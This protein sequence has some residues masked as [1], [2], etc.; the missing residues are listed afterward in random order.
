LL[1]SFSTSVL[2]MGGWSA[3]R[4]GR[5]T[6]GKDPVHIV[7]ENEWAAGPVWTC[8]KNLVPT[9]IFFVCFVFVRILCFIVLVLD[10]QCSLYRTSLFLECK[11]PL[12]SGAFLLRHQ[13]APRIGQTQSAP[14]QRRKELMEFGQQFRNFSKRRIRSLDRPASRYTD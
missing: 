12:W 5:F 14:L 11:G 3:P 6:S 4:P 7:Q 10:F 9:G 2:G 8:A 1:Y 13:R